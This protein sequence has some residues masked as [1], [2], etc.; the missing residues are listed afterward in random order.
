M[1]GGPEIKHA[2]ALG[3]GASAQFPKAA[4]TYFLFPLIITSSQS[5]SHS[6]NESIELL[7]PIN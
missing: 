1:P 5:E 2:F 7:L 4:F 3:F 6:L